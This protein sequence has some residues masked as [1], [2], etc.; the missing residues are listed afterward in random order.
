MVGERLLSVS[1]TS[2]YLIHRSKNPQGV[3]EFRDNFSCYRHFGEDPFAVKCALVQCSF[4]RETPT[5]SQAVDDGKCGI[6]GC[7]VHTP[8]AFAPTVV[9]G[10]RRWI[11]DSGAGNDSISKE[12]FKCASHLIH[13]AAV[14]HT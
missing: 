10:A 4:T 7:D 1:D 13:Q 2:Q 3:R 11:V 5:F 8:S 12:S 6:C 9:H 14:H